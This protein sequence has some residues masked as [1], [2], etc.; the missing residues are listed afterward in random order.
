[1]MEFYNAERSSWMNKENWTDN[2]NG[3]FA[4]VYFRIDTVGFDLYN[5]SFTNTDDREA[6]CKE[7]SEIIKSFGIVESSGY[8][9]NN[10]YL[11]AHPQNISGIVA[12]SKIKAIAEA[13]NNSKTMTIRWTDVYEEYALIS[14]EDYSEILNSKRE[15]MAK[16]I[17]ENCF[18]KRT[19][20]FKSRFEIAVNVQ[21]KF[22]TNRINAIEDVNTHKATFN[23]AQNVID[24]LIED[25]YLIQVIRYDEA[26]LIRSL[27]KTEQKKKGIDYESI[28]MG[29]M[30]L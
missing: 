22:K 25:G 15:E 23:F 4:K 20:L 13:I 19:N 1:M 12:K 24:Q 16:Y 11:Y 30:M 27:N 5:G 29:G 26:G 10:E 8:K 9:Q 2:G 21:E 28:L 18:T 6:F 17:V 7:A 3:N 14:D